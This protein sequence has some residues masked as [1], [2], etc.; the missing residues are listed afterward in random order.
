MDWSRKEKICAL[1]LN[2][3]F[4]F[5]PKISH[6]LIDSLGSASAVFELPREELDALFGPYSRYP[7]MI[8]ARELELAGTELDGLEKKGARFIPVSD[9]DYPQELKQCEDAPV[10]LYVLCSDDPAN[11]FN[12]RPAVSVFGT[13]DISPYGRECCRRLVDAVSRSS[14]RPAIVSGLA[15]GVDVTAHEAA[16]ECGL[17]T[18]AVLPTG[19]DCVYP[20]R[21]RPVAERIVST[22]GCALIT[23]YPPGTAPVALN[24]LRRNRIIAGLASSAV[25]VESKM[26]G[27]GMMTAR[28]AAGYGRELFAIPGRVDDIR[29]GGCNRLIH[30]NLAEP[31]VS[32]DEVCPDLGLGRFERGR[33]ESLGERVA[34]V[35]RSLPDEEVRRL[36]SMAE[37]IRKNRGIPID[38]LCPLM[39]MDYS[40]TAALAATLESDGIIEVDL[41]R[42][43]SIRTKIG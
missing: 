13:R 19:I 43:C 32:F 24:F 22:P 23:D 20:S 16:L 41:L 15:I 25:L 2:R 27:G 34:R 4:G 29:S 5:E 18:I 9:K 33:R 7:A 1:A 37:L 10:G 40:G 39:G 42:Q 28:L 17:P 8:N 14:V 26:K 30:D 36:A 35:Y 12:T 11:V 31:I 6:S 38:E 21:H 3:I